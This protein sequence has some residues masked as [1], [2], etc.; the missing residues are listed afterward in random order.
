MKPDFTYL[1]EE[2]RQDGGMT[3]TVQ[4]VGCSHPGCTESLDFKRAGGKN[5]PPDQIA[6]MAQNKGWVVDL[7][8]GK[9]LCPKHAAP[10][11]RE[12]PMSKTASMI[13]PKSEPQ[14]EPKMRRMIF[15]EIDDSYDEKGQCYVSGITDHTI[16]AKLN[17]TGGVGFPG[18]RRELRS[19]RS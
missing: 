11:K 9:H 12:E 19:C 16:A 10:E 4:V 13:P 5:K 18:P 2:R 17:T 3:Y 1:P 6:K 15:R 14:I 7:K 8:H